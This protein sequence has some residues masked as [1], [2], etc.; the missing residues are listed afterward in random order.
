MTIERGVAKLSA[1]AM[2]DPA[3]GTCVDLTPDFQRRLIVSLLFRPTARA[4]TG[5]RFGVAGRVLATLF[6]PPRLALRFGWAIGL[7]LADFDGGFISCHA[8]HLL[9]VSF[10]IDVKDR[11]P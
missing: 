1:S 2:A 10:C 9:W 6:V 3:A 5:R 4:M 11:Q 7:L 8:V